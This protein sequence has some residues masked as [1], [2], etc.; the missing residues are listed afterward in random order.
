MLSDSNLDMEH[1]V[2]TGLT[3]VQ[4]YICREH[5]PSTAP[6]NRRLRI[7]Q[8]EMFMNT[9]LGPASI[10]KDPEVRMQSNNRRIWLLENRLTVA[11][12]VKW[13]VNLRIF[14]PASIRRELDSD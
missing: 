13:E 1:L 12:G 2:T 5:I 6:D 7:E 8:N 4:R 11:T 9:V 10:W 14:C 3:R